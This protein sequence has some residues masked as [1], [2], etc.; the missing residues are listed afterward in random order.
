MFG[1]LK[2]AIYKNICCVIETQMLQNMKTIWCFEISYIQKKERKTCG[3]IK[4]ICGVKQKGSCRC[5]H[6]KMLS[7]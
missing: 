4:Q 3:V 1:V 2:L 6:Q 7:K 5:G